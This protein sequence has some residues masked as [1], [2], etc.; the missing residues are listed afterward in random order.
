MG[1]LI[2]WVLTLIVAGVP[3]IL[4]GVPRTFASLVAFYEFMPGLIARV[5][6]LP[7]TVMTHWH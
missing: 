2:G 7:H 5:M 4:V 3:L 6:L 1:P